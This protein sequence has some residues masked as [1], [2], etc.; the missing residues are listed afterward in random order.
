MKMSYITTHWRLDFIFAALV[1]ADSPNDLRLMIKLG[2][3]TDPTI[4][5][6]TDDPDDEV[7]SLRIE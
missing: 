7:P 4:Y 3:R 1:H 6:Q 2:T 5:E